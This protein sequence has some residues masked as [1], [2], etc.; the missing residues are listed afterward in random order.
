MQH[1]T[2]GAPGTAAAVW[3]EI[4]QFIAKHPATC[5]TRLKNGGR[6]VCFRAELTGDGHVLLT[7]QKGQQ[8]VLPESDFPILYTLYFRREHGESVTAQ[9]LGQPLQHLLVGPYLLVSCPGGSSGD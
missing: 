7:L 2:Q 8:H 4:R 1:T 5:H 9:A 6:G 3:R